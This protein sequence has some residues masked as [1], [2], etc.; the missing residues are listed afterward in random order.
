MNNLTTLFSTK[1]DKI[2]WITI[3]IISALSILAVYSA[4]DNLLY[5]SNETTTFRHLTRHT[6]YMALGLCTVKGIEKIFNHKWFN[7]I[8]IWWINLPFIFGLLIWAIITG[9]TIGGA[10]AERWVNVAGIFSFQPSMFA[11]LFLVV[12]ICKFLTKS[13]ERERSVPDVILLLFLPIL[14]VIAL[15]GKGNGSTALLIFITTTIVMIIGRLSWKYIGGYI[16]SVFALIIIFF[17]LAKAGIIQN[18]RI[19]TW[20]S[21]IEVHF[22]DKEKRKENN[23]NL[24]DKTYQTDLAKSA[25]IHGGFS[26]VGPGKSAIKQSLPQSVSDFIFAIVVEEY[27]LFG[28]FILLSLYGLIITRMIIISINTDNKFHSLLVISF[29]VMFFLQV[30]VN[31]AVAVNI[32]PVTGQ[33]LPLISAGGTSMLATYILLGFV[34]NISTRLS[35]KEKNIGTKQNLEDVKDIA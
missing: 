13:I 27:G 3:V 14:G 21:R 18:N 20:I 23:I 9:T 11:Y 29:A 4:S 1:G 26:G 34:L 35:I 16:L 17:A 31:I 8:S 6:L 15:V 5:L 19:D 10:S 32:I 25:I 24:E 7:L 12:Y 33:P 2:L 22:I 28:A 30:A